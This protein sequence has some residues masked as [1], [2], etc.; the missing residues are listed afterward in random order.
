MV[1]LPQLAQISVTNLSKI[2]Q[3]EEELGV[4]LIA[5]RPMEF[6]KLTEKQVNDLQKMEKDLKA[7][8]IAYD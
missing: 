7:T 3:L 8:V 6:A 1:C 2:K 4:V 5:Y